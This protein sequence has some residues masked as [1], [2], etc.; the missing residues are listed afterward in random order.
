MERNEHEFRMGIAGL[1]RV[2]DTVRTALSPR[3]GQNVSGVGSEKFPSSA[4]APCQ[5]HIASLSASYLLTA[6]TIWKPQPRATTWFCLNAPGATPSPLNGERAGVRGVAIAGV[7][8]AMQ[9]LCAIREQRG[10]RWEVRCL[11][12]NPFFVP[13]LSSLALPSTPHPGPL[14]DR[15]GEGARAGRG[16]ESGCRPRSLAPGRSALPGRT[17]GAGARPKSKRMDHGFRG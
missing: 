5:M 13:R 17:R 2:F 15:G 16:L 10:T 3:R 6:L 9:A 4:A 11:E 12:L 8:A 7:P 14:L 1:A